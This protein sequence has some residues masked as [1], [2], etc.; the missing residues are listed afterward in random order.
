MPAA[1][2][3]P[4]VPF[5]GTDAPQ[6]PKIVELGSDLTVWVGAERDARLIHKE[7]F[8]DNCYDIAKLSA[9]PCT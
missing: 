8:T 9:S 5:Q 3:L 6:D 1:P 7:I 4:G 2:E